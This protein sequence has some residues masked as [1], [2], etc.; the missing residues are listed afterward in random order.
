MTSADP[1][2]LVAHLREAGFD[3]TCGA[4]TL[5]AIDGSAKRA[6][7][8][9]RGVV[10]LPVYGEIPSEKLDE[11]ARLVQAHRSLLA[12]DARVVDREIVE[13]RVERAV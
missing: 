8:A 12:A 5:I 3:A 2:A 10:Y 13:P 7:E 9:M 6:T 1:S 4:S 11:L